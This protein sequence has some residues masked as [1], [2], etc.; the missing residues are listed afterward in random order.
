MSSTL[1]NL[2][3][4]ILLGAAGGITIFFLDIEPTP[5]VWITFF[6]IA[7]VILIGKDLYIFKFSS[8]MNTV[9]RY[10]KNS[11]QPYYRFLYAY[12][13]DNEAEAEKELVKLT[14]DKLRAYITVVVELHR[15][16][17][18]LVENALGKIDSSEH[19]HYYSAH[20]ALLKNNQ[21]DYNQHRSAIKNRIYQLLLDAEVAYHQ[22]NMA[23]AEQYGQLAIAKS[24]GVQKYLLIKTLEKSKR[25]QHRNSYF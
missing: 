25:S 4:M 22:G 17:Y 11:K 13:H 19:R 16:N 14:S 1:R 23:E 15:D 12:L 2:L 8:N 18:D 10:V 3:T 5:M 9:E 6:L 24:K 20:L 21:D 7:F